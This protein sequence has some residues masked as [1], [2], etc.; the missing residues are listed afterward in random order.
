MS[1][2]SYRTIVFALALFYTAH[3]T[4][5]ADWAAPGGSLRYLTIW[6]LILSLLVAWRVWQNSRTRTPKSWD[7]FVSATAVVNAMVVF[8]YWKLFFE[9]PNSVTET[10]EMGV[11]WREYYLHLIG[12]LLMWLDAL[13]FNWVFQQIKI[14]ALWL[15]GLVVSYILWMELIVSPM[16]DS[17]IGDVTNGFPY[18]FLNDLEL[19]GRALFYVSNFVVAFVFLLGFAALAWAVRKLSKV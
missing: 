15:S 14:A 2:L 13:F 9:D 4:L 18:P 17:P 11:W 8:L 16:N 12:P 6:G 19:S 7:A 1:I 3:T 10:G 5:N